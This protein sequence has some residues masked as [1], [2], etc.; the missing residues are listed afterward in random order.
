MTGFK[1]LST[2]V[3]FA[4]L[5]ATAQADDAPA[6]APPDK[7]N[8]RIF[9]LA[10][11]SNMAGRGEISDVDLKIHPRILMLAKD[12]SWQ[13]AVD[14]IHYDKKI[15]GAGLAKS[16]AIELV[17]RDEE[18]TIGL[19]PAACGGSPISTWEPGAYFEKTDSHPYDDAIARTKRATQD[20]TLTGILWHQG[21]ADS[22]PERS[23][24]YQH[25][26][27]GL[28]QRLRD[29]L[30]APDIPFVIGQLG[31]FPGKPWSEGRH[32]INEAHIA[33]ATEIP[34]TGFVS[35]TGLT[36]KDD[37][38]HF[39]TKSLHKFGQRYAQTYLQITK[40]IQ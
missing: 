7:E 21:E 18:I 34:M 33:V 8:F 9:L 39:N 23:A 3:L 19:V 12:G 13:H 38:T 26:L 40:Q 37:N 27:A 6:P 28:I 29:D 5:T 36:S 30:N 20:G 31:Q 25:K 10:G 22:R 16:F 14:P 15:A 11:Q 17:Q 35:S 2:V 4:L 32:T 24:V 1:L